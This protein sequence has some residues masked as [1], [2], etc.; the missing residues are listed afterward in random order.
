LHTARNLPHVIAARPVIYTSAQV[1]TIAAAAD[2]V[3]PPMPRTAHSRQDEHGKKQSER[4]QDADHITKRDDH[5]AHT[6]DAEH[7]K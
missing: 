1:A 6:D 2:S 7:T 3:L 4:A 5:A